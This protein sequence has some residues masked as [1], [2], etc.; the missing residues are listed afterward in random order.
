MGSWI[1]S[2]AIVMAGLAG[3]GWLAQWGRRRSRAAAV[4]TDAPSLREA[5]DVSVRLVVDHNAPGGL[6]AGMNYRSEGHLRLLDG[7]LLLATNHG[8]VLDMTAIERGQVRAPGPRMMILEGDHPSG[9]A[10]V[11]AELVIDDEGEW[12]NAITTQLSAG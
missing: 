1:L 12:V 2:V 8:R 4:A 10:R 3:V 5:V 9:R 7:R 6:R 11:R